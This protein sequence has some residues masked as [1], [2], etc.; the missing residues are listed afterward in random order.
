VKTLRTKILLGYGSSLL[1]VAVILALAIV[2]LLRLGRAS[3]AIL[4]ENYRSILAAEKMINDIERQD[5]G[6]LLILLHFQDLGLKE[7]RDSEVSFLQWLGRAKD[8][9]TE[10]G[11]KEL[12]EGIE[13]NYTQYL[14]EFSQLRLITDT[15]HDQA[16]NFYH[17]QVLPR[18]R[19]VRDTCI[20]LQSLNHEA[21]YASSNRARRLAAQAIP[22]ISFI[23]AA[24]II[25]GISFSLFLSRLISR[26][27]TELK[28]AV[29][30]L[31]Q[32][33][34]GVQVP[35]RGSDELALLAEA[36]N[37]MAD[38]LKQ[39]HDMNIDQ[40]LA[41]KRK[42]E[43][44]IRSVDDGL[45]VVDEKLLITNIN[46]KARSI[47]G[48]DPEEGLG[49]HILEVVRDNQIFQALKGSLET[50]QSPHLAEGE[51]IL[52]VQQGEET[53]H[54]QTAILPMR[55]RAG[56]I[57][58]A[59]LVLRDITRLK[60]LDRLKSEF[61]M[62]ASHELRT[63]LTSIGMSVSMLMESAAAKLTDQERE[64]L[65]VCHEEV[66]RLKALVNDLLD[67]SKIEA[68]KLELFFEPASPSFLSQQAVAMM[69]NQYESKG[70]NLIDEVPT[71]LPEVQADPNKIVWVLVNLLA[72]AVRYTPAGG[73]VWLRGERLGDMVQLRVQDDGPGVPREMQSRIFDKFVRLDHGE[74]T[75]GSGLGLAISKEII[76]AH[77]GVIWLES[78]P[79]QGSI[80]NFTLPLAE[81][82]K[83]I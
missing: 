15:D 27:I 22:F 17:D 80:F 61:V 53:Q 73:N 35:V 67:L 2:L 43:A 25:L 68:G 58:G 3:D 63:P 31:A 41:E 10:P 62:T 38:K 30:H 52:T 5:S 40:I 60:E 6:V 82:D 59:V 54:Y 13:Q 79:G 74:A 18:F 21:M 65:D 48:V 28:N 69:R 24:A 70:I 23:G 64:L 76:R 83:E 55:S 34:Y 37:V 71:E 51:D 4:Q 75:S 66:N 77:R 36:F 49:K 44:I 1:I 12:V 50:G 7:F 9:I 57:P 33:D 39:F 56:V 46:P 16:V 29:S 72:N 32:G 26:P 42:S 20:K 19:I 78:E 81:A 8:N 47:F 45:I 11:E 14:H